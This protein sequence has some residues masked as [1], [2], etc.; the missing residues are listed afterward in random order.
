[1]R[2][3][4]NTNNYM[5]VIADSMAVAQAAQESSKLRQTNRA[6]GEVAEEIEKVH[7]A[8]EE[9]LK[10]NSPK[11]INPVKDEKILPSRWLQTRQIFERWFVRKRRFGIG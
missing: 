2:G 11:K 6:R 10:K 8:A 9:A 4:H 7:Q 3:V 5:K 1:M